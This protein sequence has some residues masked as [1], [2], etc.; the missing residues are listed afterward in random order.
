MDAIRSYSTTLTNRFGASWNRFWFAA[1]DTFSLAVL[2]VLTGL[3]ALY[4]LLSHTADLIRW[5]G[6]NGILA[7]DRAKQIAG[8]E[9][10]TGDMPT[11]YRF[12]YLY[13]CESPAALWI[14][15][16]VGIVILTALTL[17]LRTRIMA[18]LSL[19]VVLSYVH[20][21]PVLTAQFEPV[22]TMM[23]FYLCLAPCGRQLSLDRFLALRKASRDGE[24]QQ[25]LAE[26]DRKSSVATFVLRLMQIH[27]VAF[28]LVM[29]LSKLRGEG[30]WNGESAWGLLAYS[31]SRLIDLTSL[32]G[33]PYVINFW[34][35]AI[36]A[37][38]LSFG[39]LIW[40]KTLRPLVLAVSVLMWTSLA[41][42]TGLTAFCL[43]ML[44]ANLAFVSAP[45]MRAVYDRWS[46]SWKKDVPQTI[47]DKVSA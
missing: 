17:G 39:V 47:A 44:I 35:H 8:L 14:A 11:V 5:F 27:I 3:A 29:G 13:F 24:R 46:L 9:S 23:L 45:A 34:T 2:R 31:E 7:I 26:L 12:S 28:Y 22:L 1:S 16:A 30:W 42:I 33:A 40:S 38:E 6:P 15:H 32:A 36:V 4:Y 41:L 37:F 19:L 20:R 43:L 25:M 18:A 21:A 10:A